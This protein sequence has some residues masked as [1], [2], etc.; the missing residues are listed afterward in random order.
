ML[1]ATPLLRA[2]ARRRL[3]ALAALDPVRAQQDQLRRLLRRAAGT[4]FG[5]AH[6]FAEIARVEE[7]QRRVGLR[8]YEEF[9]RDYWQAAFPR[10]DNLTWPG[11]IPYFANTSGTTGAANKRVPVSGEM[12]RANRRAALDVLVFH[13]ARHPASR[14]LAGRSL[15]LGGTTALERLAP[16]ILAGDLSGI[17]AVEVPFWARSRTFPPREVA[18]M[19]NWEAKMD[20][21]ASLALARPITGISGTASWLLLF[22]ERLAALRPGRPLAELLPMLELVVHGGVG[23]AP[24]RQRF[25]DRLAGSVAETREVYPASEGFI[26]IA[27]RG[28]GEGLR[29]ILDNGLFY[30]FVRPADLGSANPDRRWIA[31]ADLDT[32]YA[33]VL[34]TNAGMWSYVLGD[35]VRLIDRNPP[36]LLVSGRTT[37]SLSVVG[38][39]VIVEELDAATAAAARAVGGTVAD[40][41]AAPVQP[42]E[43]D[44]RGGHLFIVELEGARPGQE[45]AFAAVLDAELVRMNADYAAHRQGGYGMRPPQVRLVPA[46]SFTAWMRRRN[47]L[48]GQN[49]VPRV[50]A[51]PALLA[52]LTGFLAAGQSGH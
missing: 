38:E 47:R 13:A 18:L 21:M 36:R 4:A 9:W 45:A 15:I 1:D 27:D 25:A 5:R 44:P 11:T 40:Y 49:K 35:T 28:D 37:W 6:R 30:E 26:A 34:S 23:F 41:A 12:V 50:I 31:D 14:V 32:E 17:A 29:L 43:A 19:D 16:G 52:D 10:L 3:A 48:G 7:F 39:H 22:L 8:R 2:Y 42:D 20:A 24:Y 46:G 51:D 33:L